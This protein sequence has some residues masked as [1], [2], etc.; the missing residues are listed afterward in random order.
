MRVALIGLGNIGYKYD[1]DSQSNHFLTHAKSLVKHPDFELHWAIDIDEIERQKFSR[2]YNVPVFAKISDILNPEDVDVVVV[3]TPPTSR[4]LIAE[5]ICDMLNPRAVLMEKPLADSV[6]NG[7]KVI[8]TFREKGVPVYF[9]FM[10][11]A[12]ESVWEIKKTLI[13][14]AN[15]VSMPSISGLVW[16]GKNIESNAPH[17]LDLLIL[18]FGNPLRASRIDSFHIGPDY[19]FQVT[20]EWGDI[21]FLPHPGKYLHTEIEIFSQD[22]AI[23]MGAEDGGFNFLKPRSSSLYNGQH[24]LQGASQELP[25]N[26]GSLQYKVLNELLKGINKQ[27]TKLTDAHSALENLKIIQSVR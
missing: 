4:K 24:I 2:A 15:D 9:N 6:E 18:W 5:E 19:A 3:A 8:R 11:R 20:F 14:Y 7:I 12:S 22:F 27:F 1:L 17:F 23:R 13:E 21:I 26:L 10:R 25:L 16:Y